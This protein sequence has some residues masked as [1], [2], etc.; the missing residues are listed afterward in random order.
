MQNLALFP[1]LVVVPLHQD[2]IVRHVQFAEHDEP[3][4]RTVDLGP[5]FQE[6]DCDFG[7]GDYDCGTAADPDCEE[8]AVGVGEVFELDPGPAFGEEEFVADEGKGRG[9]GGHFAP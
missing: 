6:V 1:P 2:P 9:A 5:F 3:R 4:P 8:G 7:V